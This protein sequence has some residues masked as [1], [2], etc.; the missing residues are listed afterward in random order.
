MMHWPLNLPTVEVVIVLNKTLTR[1]EMKLLIKVRAQDASFVIDELDRRS[2]LQSGPINVTNVVAFEHS[3]GGAT[4]AEATLNDTRIK[5]EI[6]IDKI[7]FDSMKR[8]NTTLTK[9]FLQFASEEST[10]NPY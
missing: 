9:S 8:A 1:A 3:L 10:G 7:L 6:N 5:G 4:V 2:L